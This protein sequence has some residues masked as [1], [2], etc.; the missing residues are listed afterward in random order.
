MD[1]LEFSVQVDP[2]AVEAVS[3]LFAQVGYN[4]GVVVEEAVVPHPDED[5]HIDPAAP[6]SVRTYLPAGADAEAARERVARALWHLGQLRPVG[7]LVV[8]PMREEEWADAWKSHYQ[9]Q[10]VGRRL[11]IKPSWLDYAPAPGE[12]IIELDPGMAFGTGLHPTTRLCLQALE[13]YVAA[14]MT[15]LLDLGTGSAILAIGAARLGGPDL[16]IN[17]LD[18]DPVA[19]AVAQENVARNGLADVI[20]I[21]AG[22][23]D[24]A[25]LPP[26]RYHLI[27]ANILARVIIALAPALAAALEPGGVVI[28]SGILAERGDEV[29]AALQAAGLRLLERRQEGDWLAIVASNE[30]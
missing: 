25:T 10:R 24:A 4:Q 2:E 14:G 28:T 11:T 3:E 12:L 30:R 21:A 9:T 1:W 5:Y 27:V 15:R 22:S 13:D 29:D 23:L 18:T 8:R 7:P 6:V 19:V 26:R 20:T 16:R 17:A